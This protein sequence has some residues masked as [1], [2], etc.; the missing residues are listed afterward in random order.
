MWPDFSKLALVYRMKNSEAWHALYKK[1]LVHSSVTIA[2]WTIKFK[3]YTSL[4]LNYHA[5]QVWPIQLLWQHSYDVIPLL[6]WHAMHAMLLSFSSC[7]SVL[8]LKS[9][10][11]KF[12]QT[13]IFSQIIYSLFVVLHQMGPHELK[14]PI[15]GNNSFYV[16]S[17]FIVSCFGI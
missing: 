11:L 15:W 9:Q 2:T 16:L 5:I 6:Q 4:L 10:T 14:L 8:I 13:N 12:S 1:K 17:C 7:I 3:P